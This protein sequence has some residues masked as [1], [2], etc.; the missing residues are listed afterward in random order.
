MLNSTTMIPN[1][2][3]L[4]SAIARQLLTDHPSIPLRACPEESEGKSLGS[5]SIIVNGSGVQIWEDRYLPFGDV[6]YHSDTVTNT[7]NVNYDL[8]T[9]KSDLKAS[10]L[11]RRTAICATLAA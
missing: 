7:A 2:G 8:L 6:R 4:I 1:R 10:F 3:I 5:S 11:C 9:G